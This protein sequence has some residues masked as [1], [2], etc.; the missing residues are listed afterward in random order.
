MRIYKLFI[1]N[2]IKRL[3]DKKH[4]RFSKP[5]FCIYQAILLFLGVNYPK[6]KHNET[7]S[8]PNFRSYDSS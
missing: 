1:I 5:F 8:S 2:R 3:L 6:L 7:V 4:T